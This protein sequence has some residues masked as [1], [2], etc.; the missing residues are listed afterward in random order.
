MFE[1][2]GVHL[3]SYFFLPFLQQEMDRKMW[4]KKQV[5]LLTKNLK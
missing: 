2:L 5:K 4:I 1:N 3:L